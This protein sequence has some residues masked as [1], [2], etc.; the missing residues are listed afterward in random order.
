MNVKRPEKI[1]I[2]NAIDSVVRSKAMVNKVINGSV[3]DV[4]KIID[5][6]EK[7]KSE[8]VRNIAQQIPID[9]INRNKLGFKI[10][11]LKRNGINSIYTLHERGAERVSCIYV[12]SEDSAFRMCSMAANMINSISRGVKV[13]INP[14]KRSTISDSVIAECTKILE[15]E[16][17]QRK[18]KEIYT[19]FTDVFETELSHAKKLNNWLS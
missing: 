5:G 16:P 15:A 7:L 17:L 13:R 11:L 4:K 1:R 10:N 18:A 6:C 2:S 14:E 12:I 8:E 3:G 19:E 9:E